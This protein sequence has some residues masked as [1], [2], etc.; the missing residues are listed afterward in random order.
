MLFMKT[1]HM[2]GEETSVALTSDE[3]ASS[4]LIFTPERIEMLQD[5]AERF[6][7][8]ISKN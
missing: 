5:Q 1:K 6:I 3:L 2:E 8:F 4:T 7:E